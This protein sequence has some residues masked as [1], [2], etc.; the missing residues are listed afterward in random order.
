VIKSISNNITRSDYILVALLLVFSGNPIVRFFDK[1]LIAVVAVLILFTKYKQ[2]KR[3]FFV[4]FIA[5]ALALLSLFILQFLTFN[6]VSW[7]GAFRY[8]AI[9]F[10]GGL[11]FHLVSDRL[12]FTFFVILYYLSLISLFL[13]VLINL[14]H[15]PVPGLYWGS[16]NLTYI[17]YTFVKDPH[18]YRNCGMFWEPGAFS[19]ILTLCFALNVKYL[20][21]L[22]KE[23]KFKIIVLILALLT[24]KSTTGYIVF[25]II[26]IYYLI[27]F[28]KNN[29]IKFALVPGLLLI[30]FLV[31]E[32]A[33]FLQEKI[34][35]QSE[36]TSSLG[37]GEFSN[38][39]FGSFL[40]DMKYIKKHPLVGNGMNEKTRYADDPLLIQQMKNSETGT[41]GNANGFSN[42]LASLGIPFMFFYLLLTFYA[43]NKFDTRVAFL[44]ILVVLLNLWGEQWLLY[45]IFTSLLFMNLR[46]GNKYQQT[47]NLNYA[48]PPFQ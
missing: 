11:I 39:R 9:F 17:I 25:F 2:V 23:H 31:Y 18:E 43:I 5:I 27:F 29:L 14:L 19:G 21:T 44:V 41:L 3:E 6:F 45:P 16:Q 30:S 34:N 32:N 42:F 8:I 38:N 1:S 26:V 24:T 10:F 22:W 40:I 37:K 15:I 48:A 47:Y 35:E 33:D 20:P 36:K 12:P 46:P 13:Y 4:K 28:I 7:L